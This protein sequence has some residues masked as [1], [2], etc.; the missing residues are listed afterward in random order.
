MSR[1]ARQQQ[2][3][4]SAY[5][6]VM[7]RGHNREVVF[8]SDEDRAYFLQLLDRYCQRSPVWLYHYCLM[9]NHFH[10]LVHSESAED[11]SSWMAGLLRAYVHNFHRCN[12]FV[13]HL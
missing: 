3:A 1:V 12:G 13:G 6:H 4:A 11:L 8:A 9:S 2:C 10:L 5:Y 7:N